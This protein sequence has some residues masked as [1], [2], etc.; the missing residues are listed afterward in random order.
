MSAGKKGIVLWGIDDSR[1]CGQGPVTQLA[2]LVVK[3]ADALKAQDDGASA[4]VRYNPVNNPGSPFTGVV[5]PD[6]DDERLAFTNLRHNF[7]QGGKQRF[8][9]CSRTG[10][11][12][13]ASRP[14]ADWAARSSKCGRRVLRDAFKRRRR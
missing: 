10:P 5:F 2:Y 9:S 13:T 3:S 8:K 6:Q 14:P 12:L 1:F 11:M 4:T 7:P